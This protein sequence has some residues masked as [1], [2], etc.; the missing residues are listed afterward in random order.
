MTEKTRIIFV[1]V[2]NKP[3]LKPLCG[4]TKTGKLINRVIKELPEDVEILKT[5]LFNVD[6]FPLGEDLIALADEWYWTNMPTSKDIIVLL[7]QF[8][9]KHFRFEMD[10]VIK[11]A[12]PAS[13][14]SHEAMNEYVLKTSQKITK[15]LN[16]TP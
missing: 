11:V 3:N 5:N 12:H 7:G 16:Q 2:H 9:H 13:K 4:S 14:R 6:Y 1:G 15:L 10:N 8:T